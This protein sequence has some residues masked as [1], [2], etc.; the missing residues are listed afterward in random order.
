[1]T[2][3]S[4]VGVIN[5]DAPAGSSSIIIGVGGFLFLIHSGYALQALCVTFA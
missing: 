2:F 3:S 4:S 5:A 1:M